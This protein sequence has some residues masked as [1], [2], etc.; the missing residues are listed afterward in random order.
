VLFLASNVALLMRMRSIY[1]FASYSL[2][3]SR[4]MSVINYLV[5]HNSLASTLV[6]EIDNVY[7]MQI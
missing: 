6:Y 7:I 2:F 1:A 5:S 3:C 4:C